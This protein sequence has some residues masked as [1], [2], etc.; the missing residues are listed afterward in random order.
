M[1]LDS[2]FIVVFIR[3]NMFPD[4]QMVHTFH[5]GFLIGKAVDG[6]CQ[7]R[8]TLTG[9]PSVLLFGCEGDVAIQ[10]AKKDLAELGIEYIEWTDPDSKEGHDDF[11]L[12][13]I[14]SQPIT[15]SQ[16]NKLARYRTWTDR[17]NT[18]VNKP[19]GK[20]DEEIAKAIVSE[21]DEEF[22]FNQALRMVMLVKSCS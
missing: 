17:N 15:K 8:H 19:E 2:M 16:R 4:H 22:N 9:H 12:T 18:S 7:K 21:T 3:Q 5:L 11:G 20:P 13:G 10:N 14:V 1:N 6:Y